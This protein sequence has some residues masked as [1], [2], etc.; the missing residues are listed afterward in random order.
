MSIAVT[1]LGTDTT[2]DGVTT[3]TLSATT[4]A[5]ALIFVCCGDQPGGTCADTAGNVYTRIEIAIPT[6]GEL[7]VFYCINALPMSGGTITYTKGSPDYPATMAG[8]YA[9]GVALSFAYDPNVFASA[10]GTSAAPSVQSGHPQ[11]KGALLIAAIAAIGNGFTFSQ[12]T[13]DG[14]TSPPDNEAINGSN[15]AGGYLV[16]AGTGR[17]TFAPTWS[18]STNWAAIVVGFAPTDLYVFPNAARR[19]QEGM[20]LWFPPPPPFIGGAQPYAPRYP[21]EIPA[22]THRTAARRR[23]FGV[24]R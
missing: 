21:L 18:A 2:G 9:T 6:G 19:L 3:M 13:T 14:W 11:V 10:S 16:A 12:D 15:V 22:C 20:G 4:P 23:Q 17:Q 8:L 24:G 1:D 5:G 7:L